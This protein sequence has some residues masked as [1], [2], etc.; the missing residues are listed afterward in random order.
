MNKVESRNHN[1]NGATPKS[2]MSRKIINAKLMKKIMLLLILFVAIGNCYSQDTQETF[3]KTCSNKDV[4]IGC[5]W[6]PHLAT[7][8]IHFKKDGTFIFNDVDNTVLKGKYY[9]NEGVISLSYNDRAAQKFYLYFT[10]INGEMSYS[11]YNYNKTYFFVKDINN[12]DCK[13]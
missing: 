3:A 13:W 1:K 6:T 8:N 7:C 10:V 5:F 11:I 12:G 9:L 2:Q 4:L